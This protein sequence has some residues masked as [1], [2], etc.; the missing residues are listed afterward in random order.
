MLPV[1]QTLDADRKAMECEC[2][3]MSKETE[4]MIDF[5]NHSE[6]HEISNFA[7]LVSPSD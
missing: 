5:M 2:K 6:E 1:L 4:S 7:N 3:N